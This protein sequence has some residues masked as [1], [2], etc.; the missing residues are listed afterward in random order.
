[1]SKFNYAKWREQYADREIEQEDIDKIIK[2]CYRIHI[3]SG[4]SEPTILTSQLVNEMWKYQDCQILHFFTLSNQKFFAESEK[5]A[6]SFRHNS[7]S[8][9]SSP[10]MRNAI[11][12]GKADFTPCSIADV[13]NMIGSRI[14]VDVALI[15]VSPP[16]RNGFCS[17]GI[18]VDVNYSIVKQAKVVVAHVNPLMPITMGNSFIRF[19]EDI[20]YFVYKE[21]P[22]LTIPPPKIEPVYDKIARNVARLIENGATLSF[23]TTK[24]AYALPKY[25]KNKKNLALYTEV[26]LESLIELIDEGIINCSENYYNHCIT[27][28]TIGSE[29]VYNFVDE[30]PFIEFHPTKY[31]VNIENIIRNKKLCSIYGA[32]NVDLLGQATN[33]FGTTLYGGLGGEPEFMRGSALSEGGKAII[34]LPS[35]TKDGKSRILP[36]LPPGPVALRTIDVDYVVTEFGIAHLYGKCLRDRV[37]QMI[38][39]AHPDHREYLL[40]KA[41]EMHYVYK[42][43]VLPKTKDGV[44]VICPDIEWQI[45]TKNKEIIRFRPVLPTDERYLQEFYYSLSDQDRLHR[46]LSRRKT[47]PHHETQRMIN[48]DYQNSMMIVGHAGEDYEDMQIVAEGA[49]YRNENTNL[50]EVSVTVHPK[51]RNQG[52]AKKIFLK[53]IELSLERGIDGICGEIYVTNQAMFHVLNSLPYKVEFKKEDVTYEFTIRFSDRKTS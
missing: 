31:V 33:H 44:V 10:E 12:L 48:C 46:F 4:C 14:P 13:A 7:L 21:E 45:E 8:I 2:P 15:Q 29:K 32:L 20:D 16:E 51:Y 19:D 52:L 38:S 1:M 23:G 50:A 11:N 24:V 25:L 26:M 9:I 34:A 3:G 5:L 27:T 42:D 17:L 43:Q 30:N 22:M 35:T 28:F 36:Y 6:M 18:N 41:K 47:F 39:I 40:Q 37:L 53:I 49:F